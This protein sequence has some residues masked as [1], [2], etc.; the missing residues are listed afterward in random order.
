MPVPYDNRY[1]R[2]VMNSVE[3]LCDRKI[4]LQHHFRISHDI[5][6]VCRSYIVKQRL[7]ARSI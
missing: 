2:D 1:I 7:F 5:C 6:L 3:M 4:E